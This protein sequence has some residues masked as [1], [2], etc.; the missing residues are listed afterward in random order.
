MK[1][2]MLVPILILVFGVLIIC[3]GYATDKNVS[4]KDYRFVSGT[5]INKDYNS[6]ASQ[7]KQVRHGVGFGEEGRQ[8]SLGGASDNRH[9]D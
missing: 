9:R 6:G 4:K 5:W 8:V 2:R 3:E 7:A 1:A